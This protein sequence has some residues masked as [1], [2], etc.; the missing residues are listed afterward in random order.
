MHHEGNLTHASFP[1]IVKDSTSTSALQKT[2]LHYDGRLAHSIFPYN[3]GTHPFP[4]ITLY[5]EGSPMHVS[6]PCNT[7]T[8]AFPKCTLHYDGKQAFA[9]FPSGISTS[10]VPKTTLHHEGILM[11]AN[12]PYIIKESKRSIPLLMQYG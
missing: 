4:K 3:I 8:S 7:S 9:I 12:S 10:A 2:T 11:H 6:S 5:H 1:C